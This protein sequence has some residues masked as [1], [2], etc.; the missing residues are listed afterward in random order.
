MNTT[1]NDP[2]TFFQSLP[3]PNPLNQKLAELLGWTQIR[4][5]AAPRY[6]HK[7]GGNTVVA[8]FVGLDPSGK[9]GQV[10]D[11]CG[12]WAAA[13]PLIRTYQIDV[14]HSW[15][16]VYFRCDDKDSH[17]HKNLE[18][19]ESQEIPD[20]WLIDAEMRVGIVEASI[21]HLERLKEKNE[22]NP[23]PAT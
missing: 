10:P 18:K 5:L 6:D 16:K 3:H 14:M 19:L 20:P 9:Q 4:L 2:Q 1:N 13:G 8:I 17:V 11:W 22:T 7:I 15:G 12:N 23:V 21:I